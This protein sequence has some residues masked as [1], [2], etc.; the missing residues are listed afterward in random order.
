MEAPNQ[1]VIVIGAGVIGLATAYELAKRGLQVTVL[2]EKEPGWAASHGNA[3]MI[4]P[5]AGEPMINPH[6]MKAG[7]KWMLTRGRQSPMQVSFL[8]LPGL[9]GWGLRVLKACNQ[10]NYE[11]GKEAFGKLGADVLQQYDDYKQDGVEYEEFANEFLAVF[12]DKK[13]HQEMVDSLGG[14]PGVKIFNGN[15]ARELEP[16]LSENVVGAGQLRG[17]FK[18]VYPPSVTAGLAKRLK[19]MGVNI[20]TGIRV[21]GANRTGRKVDSLRTATGQTLKA[22]HFVVAAGGWSG[23]IAKMLGSRVPITGGK[24][25]CINIMDPDSAPGQTLFLSEYEAVVIPFNGSVRLTGF[26]EVSGVNMRILPRRIKALREVTGRYLKKVPEGKTEVEWTGMRACT[27]DGVPLIGQL[28]GL[29]NAWI[30]SGHWHFGMTLA[31]PTGLMLAELITTGQSTVENKPF[32][33]S[34]F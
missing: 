9:I 30:G 24:G 27:P 2:E 17:S 3:G 5:S 18:S 11:E 16:L 22:D 13:I 12:L 15:E 19:S 29:D 6:H 14:T 34:R 20:R 32:S 26:M 1:D 25:Y 10:R 21:A 23:K 7:L 8:Q 28:K 4:F 33:P 31:P